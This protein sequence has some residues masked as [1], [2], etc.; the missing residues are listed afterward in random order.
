MKG[1]AS[2]LFV[3][4]KLIKLRFYGVD[5]DGRYRASVTK[6]SGTDVC[7]LKRNRYASDSPMLA[8]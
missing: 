2:R 3:D 4:G 8:T 5:P 6:D 1:F 7:W